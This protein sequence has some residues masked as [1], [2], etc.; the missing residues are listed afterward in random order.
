[1]RNTKRPRRKTT[2]ERIE[3]RI[4]INLGVGALAYVLLYILHV[5]CYMAPVP[6]FICAG[7]LAVAGAGCYIRSIKERRF[8]NYGHM[9]AGLT[10]G[11]LFT[12]LAMLA[13]WVLGTERVVQ[14]IESARFWRVLFN[15]R[16][17]VQFVCI[18]GAVYLA[19][20][21]VYNIR[22]LVKKK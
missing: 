5:H 3:N 14:L 8:R 17:E 7:L 9:F 11:L 21:L 6:T 1:M 16:R 20:M 12:K 2:A 10:L 13:S 4:L 19:G 15:S 22:L 18:A